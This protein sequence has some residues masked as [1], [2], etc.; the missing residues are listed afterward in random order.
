MSLSATSKRGIILISAAIMIIAG[1]L[2]VLLPSTSRACGPGMKGDGSSYVHVPILNNTGETLT[3]RRMFIDVPDVFDVCKK[4]KHHNV[5][6][7][8]CSNLENEMRVKAISIGGT[9]CYTAGVDP[10]SHCHRHGE[11]GD[12]PDKYLDLTTYYEFSGTLDENVE[13]KITFDV[14]PADLPSG[15]YTIKYYFRYSEDTENRENT[16]SFDL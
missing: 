15:T 7:G 4:W 10:T 5:C 14:C 9:D 8:E 3:I 12:H 6:S 1:A 13:C 2:V 16:V 11:N